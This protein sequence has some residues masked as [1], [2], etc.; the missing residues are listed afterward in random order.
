MY[1]GAQHG[2]EQAGASVV[3]Y[4]AQ[5]L[6]T[7]YDTDPAVAA[8]VDNVE[9]FLLPIMNPDGYVYHDRWN[10]NFVD[11][12]RNW[13]GPG[14]GE[15]GSGGP[16][17]FSEPETAAMRDFF[18]SHPNVRVHIDFHG[19]IDMLMW[20]WGHTPDLCLDNWTFHIL[21]S[22]ARDLVYAAGGGYYQI[23]PHWWTI[24][25]I[26]GGSLDYTYGDLGIWA[27]IFELDDDDLPQICEE[28]LPT[29]LFLSGWIS[30]CN[31]N[32]IPDADDITGGSSADCN[33]NDVPDECESQADC[34]NDGVLDIC[35]FAAGSPDCNGNA[36]PDACD[37]DQGTSEDCTGNGVPDECEPDCNE[38]GIAD[39]CDI[40]DGTSLDCNVNGIPDEC[41]PDCNENG[42]ADSCDITDGTSRDEDGNG[43]P[44]E[45]QLLL[46][47][48]ATAP[49]G[50][51]GRSWATAYR[52]L[53]RA[54]AEPAPDT[55]SMIWVAAGT[56]T[57][58]HPG[59]DREATFQ[60]I[61]GVAVYG[62]FA[63]GETNLAQR[64]P[65]GNPTI[66]SGD[67]NG[68]DGP[69]FAGN[70]ENS[71]HVV[72]GS[73]T[74][75]TAVLD[76]FTI[77]AGN[78][79]V[80]PEADGDGAG[81]YNES[82]SPTITNCTVS[83]NMAI[84]RGAGIQCTENS[85]PTITNCTI[86]GNTVP[87]HGGGV[88]CE[89]SSSPRITNCMIT[90]NSTS[91]GNG[92]GVYCTGHSS[93]TITNCTI[94]GNTSGGNGGGVFC[95]SGSSPTITNCTISGNTA[96]YNGGGVYSSGS[97]S[98]PTITNCTII[99]NTA[100]ANGG[101]VYCC[102]W[103]SPRVTNSTFV[104]NSA[105][106]GR[107]VACDSYQQ[108]SPSNLEM[109]NCILW[110]GGDEIWNND[111]STITITYTDL[112]GGWPGDGN[113]SDDPLFVDPDGPDGT[114]GTEDDNLRL[115]P[116]SPGINTGDPDF[117]SQVGE[118]DLDGHVRVLCS[119]VDMG[120]Y[121][122]GIGDFDC[123]QVVDLADFA[124]WAE[125]MTGPAG[126]PCADGCEAF[127]FDADDDVDFIDFAGLQVV[128]TEGNP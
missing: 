114:P 16:Y 89:S 67:L 119:R 123:D 4:A 75:E 70:D 116:G 112:Q 107:G 81:I 18:L 6:L 127:D 98:S 66:L 12:N 92:G 7:N 38:N 110:D 125:C 25:P 85:N 79:D 63:G 10:A 5:H 48:D 80:F 76:G 27:F 106:N 28:F 26:S 68:D 23:G 71:Y 115:S 14:S 121:E 2:N 128:L 60:L 124:N 64:D 87:N 86:T 69:D 83:G 31:G 40:Q 9:W 54:L 122:F 84:V 44:D 118:T 120:A 11:L 91:Y 113:I 24:Y 42:V 108:S 49:P 47:V 74:D 22:E 97:S 53:R 39:L 45:C 56:Y 101:G 17:Q 95:H 93:P 50:G 29:M 65:V 88:S 19:Y 90:G 13:G 111:G 21:G 102:H 46:F 52:R 43:V 33:T 1:H 72:T 126:G 78:A 94:T 37:L 59:G 36:V 61:S 105:L 96:A 109:S 20:P 82:G 34:N 58:A 77:T 41:E 62:G 8:L 32:G 117:E 3:A 104:A 100:T 51:D 73:G 55:F 30:D 99:G 103:S 15:S 57:P 35:D